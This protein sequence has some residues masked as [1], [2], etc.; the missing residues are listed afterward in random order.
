MKKLIS[1]ALAAGIALIGISTVQAISES[2]IQQDIETF[3]G[4]FLKR[5]PGLT[6]EDFQDGVNALPQYA[7]RRANWELAME[8]P[9]YEPEM[10]KAAEEWNTPFANGKSLNDCD[11]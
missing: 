2:E 11:L 4:Y 5:F 7:H 3:Q 1:L 8:F 9:P 10:E 6:I